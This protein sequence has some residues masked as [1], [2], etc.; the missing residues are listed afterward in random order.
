[1]ERWK[2]RSVY[3]LIKIYKYAK[4]NYKYKNKKLSPKVVH[5]VDKLINS[6]V[7]K[8][9]KKGKKIGKKDCYFTRKVL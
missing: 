8:G 4:F 6:G 3:D 5:T 9:G 7:D 2:N 1:M